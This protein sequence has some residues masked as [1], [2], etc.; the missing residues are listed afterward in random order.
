MK[1]P[2][3]FA[4]LDGRE[5]TSSSESLT[6]KLQKHPDKELAL[7]TLYLPGAAGPLEMTMTPEM[8]DRFYASDQ[9]TEA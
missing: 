3:S 9:P 5:F 1:R 2:R 4:D 6:L 8:F 7:F